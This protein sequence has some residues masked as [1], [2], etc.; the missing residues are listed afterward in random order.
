[1]SLARLSDDLQW[2]LRH[3]LRKHIGPGVPRFDDF[4]AA[5]SPEFREENKSKFA[6]L[7]FEH[8]GDVIHKWVHYLPVYDRL[9]L[10]YA[11]SNV[12]MLE[13]GVSKGGSLA[14][15]RKALGDGATI[16]GIDIDPKCAEFDGKFGK[17]RIG[18][19][20][21]ASFLKHVVEEMGGV[22]LVLDDGSHVASHQRASF[23]VLFPLLSE[24]GLY[25]VED[26]HTSY[27]HWF[28]G[29]LRRRGTVIE[30]MKD[31]VD[32][33]HRH[34]LEDGRNKGDQI[35][36]IESIQFFDSIIAVRKRKQ[37][38]RRRVQIP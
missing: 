25:I 14:L 12:R 16:F 29:G 28:E 22:D 9:V 8:D 37:A 30:F 36:P 21:D 1:M 26:T 18:S 20:A 2:R 15:W 6:D 3:A 35:P 17:V 24:G 38:V 32:D 11:G 5:P 13:I 10:P 4:A 19:Q 27:W 23:E 31:K 33:M 34:Y 7:F